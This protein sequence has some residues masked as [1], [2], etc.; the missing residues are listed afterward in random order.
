MGVDKTLESHNQKVLPPT[1]SSP[2]GIPPKVLSLD[3]SAGKQ[4]I[5]HAIK[6]GLTRN[7]TGISSMNWLQSLRDLGAENLIPP[8]CSN[9]KT[10]ALPSSDQWWE[11]SPLGHP[12][13][14]S[15][16]I[17]VDVIKEP[18]GCSTIGHT[19]TFV[20]FLTKGGEP[21][22]LADLT[23]FLTLTGPMMLTGEIKH[24]CTGVYEV[25]YHIPAWVVP[26]EYIMRVSVECEVSRVADT[27]GWWYGS[28]LYVE[29]LFVGVPDLPFDQKSLSVGWDNTFDYVPQY[30]NAQAGWVWVHKNMLLPSHAQ[31]SGRAAP[32]GDDEEGWHNDMRAK[33]CLYTL[34]PQT[35][36]QNLTHKMTI[37]GDSHARCLYFHV[38]DFFGIP[39]VPLHSKESPWHQNKHQAISVPS[40]GVLEFDFVWLDGIYT[41]HEFGCA[42]RGKYSHNTEASTYT[43]L[44]PDQ[45]MMVVNAAGLWTATHCEDFL[46]AHKTHM[47][48][49]YDWV[50][51]YTLDSTK[52]I[53]FNTDPSCYGSVCSDSFMTKNGMPSHSRA[54]LLNAL[55]WTEVEGRGYLLFDTWRDHRVAVQDSRLHGDPMHF[56]R[57]IMDGVNTPKIRGSAD[58][59]RTFKFVEEF[60]CPSLTEKGF[61]SREKKRR[62]RKLRQPRL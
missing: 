28:V 58:R 23:L 49:F 52:K 51:R 31:W 20:L 11:R 40:V 42:E 32:Y 38:L 1:H 8:T 39:P 30:V 14:M 10:Q 17:E 15:Q 53:W 16:D 60:L 4:E 19:C 45:D 18:E 5:Y 27:E 54:F 2:Q 3:C 13:Y 12:R 48:A 50:G 29:K 25:S 35:S 41:N 6:S 43:S 44:P 36:G 34:Q 9:T 46:Q 61:Y 22:D 56:S 62:K 24:V 21:F 59:L 47:K 33:S 7:H 55:E 26:G 57:V 37:Y